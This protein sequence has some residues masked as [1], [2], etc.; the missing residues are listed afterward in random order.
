[1]ETMTNGY[2]QLSED[3]KR[4]ER[5]ILYLEDNYHRQPELKEIAQSVH[6]S[7]FHFQRLF[8]RWAGVSPKKFM[9][10]LTLDHAKKLL[11]Q[12]KSV[13]DATYEAGLSSPGRLH[14]LF[15]N[16]E[17]VT[18]GEFKQKGAGLKISYGIHPSPFGECLLAVT[19]RGICGLSFI[20]KENPRKAIRY[21]Q[22]KWPEAK[23]VKKPA[24]T[25]PYVEKIFSSPAGN[26]APKLN[27]F[28]QGTNFQIKVW[29]ALLKIPAGC[30]ASYEE[31]AAR[32]GKPTA[33]RAVGSAVANNYIAYLIPCHRVIQKI[34]AFGNYRWGAPRKK[35]ML[36]WESVKREAVGV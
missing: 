31:V 30:I 18:P 17:A 34:G 25:K 3:Y 33:S 10:F 2:S 1:M 11:E 29:E 35:A 19:E 36:V 26:G 15:V 28:L 7:E 14:D 9:Q 23:L 20:E 6:L 8:T 21:Q 16:I 27:L 5:A 12:S 32:I 4:M 22:S 13:L 24:A